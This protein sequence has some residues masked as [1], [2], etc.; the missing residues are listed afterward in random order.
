M[1]SERLAS[2]LRALGSAGQS[3][4]DLGR[5]VCSG[6]DHYRPCAFTPCRFVHRDSSGAII[7]PVLKE[8]PKLTKEK[9]VGQR[10]ECEGCGYS[11]CVFGKCAYA[12]SCC[13]LFLQEQHGRR[14]EELDKALK[15]A[16]KMVDNEEGTDEKLDAALHHFWEHQG[17]ASVD[18]Q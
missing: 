11:C 6:F 17:K 8:T 7:T 9:G 18:E 14:G 2:A 4:R 5:R 1:D 3:G 15:E 12:C 13:C 16:L 10:G